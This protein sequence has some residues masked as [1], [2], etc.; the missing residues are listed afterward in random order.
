[1]SRPV[2]AVDIGG[3]KMVAGVVHPDGR[4]CHQ[5]R[6]PTPSTEHPGQAEELFAALAGLVAGVLEEAAADGLEVVA[7][8]VGCGGPMTAG[9]E[10]VSPVNIAAWRSFPLRERLVGVTGS[11]VVIDNDA[12]ALT[13]AEGW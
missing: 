3:T 6:I 1:M 2:L 11:A 13:L 9:G 12:K 10:Q 8:G 7:C 5:A 4:V